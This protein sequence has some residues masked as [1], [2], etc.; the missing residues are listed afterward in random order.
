MRKI[1]IFFALIPIETLAQNSDKG[2][3][4]YQAGNYATAIQEW[5]PLAEQGD[6]WTQYNL[7]SMYEYGEGLPQNYAEAVKWYRLAAEQGLSLAQNNVG[8][9]YQNGQGV[10]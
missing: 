2:F 5:T 6:A 1:L 7:I 9:M 4:T 3:D 8:L 10:L